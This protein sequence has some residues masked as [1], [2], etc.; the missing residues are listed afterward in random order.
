MDLRRGRIAYGFGHI[1]AGESLIFFISLQVNPTNVG[2]RSQNVELDDG[3][4]Q[5]LVVHHHVTIYP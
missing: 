2:R 3:A 1:P 4:K 5:I